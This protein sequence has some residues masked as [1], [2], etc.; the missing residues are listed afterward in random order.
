MTNSASSSKIPISQEVENPSSFNFSIPPPNESHSTPICGVGKTDEFIIPLAKV[1]DSHV[2]PFEENF[3]CSPTL[4][5]SCDKSQNSE[6]QSIAKPIDEPSAEEV[7]VASRGVSS[8]MSERFFEGDFPE[9]RGPE[10]NILAIRAKLVATQSL[11]S[12]Q[13]NVQPA[14][15]EPDDRS[16]EQGPLSLEPIF[17]QTP[18]SFDVETEEEE[19]EPPLRWNRAGVSLPLVGSFKRERDINNRVGQSREGKTSPQL[20]TYVL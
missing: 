12:L 18:K 3:P 14:F 5:L 10:S 13:G 7:E 8:T 1:V 9:G 20:V 17:D 15:S 19:E 16:Q 2:L 11:T 4:V 6:A